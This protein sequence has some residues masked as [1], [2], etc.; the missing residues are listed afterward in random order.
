MSRIPV[1]VPSSARV[2][3]MLAAV[4]FV[5]RQPEDFTPRDAI[6]WEAQASQLLKCRVGDDF[7]GLRSGAR[8][9][10]EVAALVEHLALPAGAAIVDLGCGPGLYGNRLGARGYR[11]T[12]I[13]IADAVVSHAQAEADAHGW[14]CCY[15]RGS[16]LALPFC[17]RFDAALLTS[18]MVNH[19]DRAELACLLGGVRRALVPA[20]RLLLEVSVASPGLTRRPDTED[21]KLFTLPYSPWSAHPHDW[22]ERNLCFGRRRERVIHH[23][24]VGEDGGVAE[25]WSRRS[26]YPRQQL[27]ARLEREGFV[28]QQWFEQGLVPATAPTSEAV[29]VLAQSLR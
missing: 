26:L 20:G 25:H 13:D 28:V 29:W 21:C 19:L 9:E 10:R 22:L 17:R 18:S 7:M 12:G 14:S 1:V 3:A 6:P 24:I 23:V 15:Q 8:V 27:T 5:R 16:F 4:P 2:D 11:V